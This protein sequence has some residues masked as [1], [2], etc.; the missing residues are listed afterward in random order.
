MSRLL[1]PALLVTAV[2]ALLGFGITPAGAATSIT[3]ATA[4]G[5]Q[6]GSTASVTGYVVGQP[7]ATSTVVRSNFPNDYALA[8]ADSA[9]QTS[10][11]AML[12]VQIPTAFRTSY[13]LQS[14]PSLLGKQI[15][16]TGTLTAY[17]SHPGLK[18]ATAFTGGGGTDPGPDPGDYYAGAEG[19]TG[20]ALKAALHTI[21]SNQTK[22]TYDQVWTA[23]KDTDQDPANSNNVIEI[24]SGRSIA[25]SSQ[26]G[27]ADDWNREH[28]WAKSHGDFGT[29]TGPGTDVHHLRP[30]DVSVNV[31]SSSSSESVVGGGVV[32]GSPLEM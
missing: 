4:I 5:R 8:L 24:Y 17:F 13:G 31:E 10:T 21:I 3:V 6:D 28:V 9:S 14:N 20:A 27:D 29:A 19:K 18:N 15:T 32:G 2:L 25:K 11:S 16:V 7:T 23:L 26:G 22:L 12:Y 1:R 30:E